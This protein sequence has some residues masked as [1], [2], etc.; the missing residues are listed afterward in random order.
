MEDHSGFMGILNGDI[1]D[2]RSIKEIFD[3]GM[4]VC[5][6]LGASINVQDSIDDPQSTFDN[7]VIGTFN[8]LEEC[9]ENRVKIVFASTCMVYDRAVRAGGLTESDPVK[10]ASP[11]AGAKLSGE[12]L[13]LSYYYAYGLPAVVLRPFNTYG[14]YQKSGGEGGVVS[15]FIRAKLSGEKLRIYGDG[16]Q[17]RDLLYVDDCARFIA[18]AGYSSAADGHILN[19]GSGRDIAINDLAELIAGD[20]TRILH[21]DH[22]H[23]QSEIRKLVCDFGK[24]RSLLGWEPTV[25]LEDGV[26]QTEAWIRAKLGETGWDER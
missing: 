11:Y 1:K 21:V 9:R 16:T 6:H 4:D 26:R 20:R 7:D 12:H 13:V 2:S 14:P 17:T 18:M 23:P 22:I 24:A 3:N 10:P 8:V 15:I 5:Y 25:K 19:A